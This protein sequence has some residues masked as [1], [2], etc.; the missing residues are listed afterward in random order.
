VNAALDEICRLARAELAGL[1]ELAPPLLGVLDVVGSTAGDRGPGV[2]ADPAFALE[3]LEAA[4]PEGRRLSPA[5]VGRVLD[6]LRGRAGIRE[7]TAHRLSVAEAARD[8]EEEGFALHAARTRDLYRTWVRRLV[9][10]HGEV[11]VAA[12]T[13]VDLAKLVALHTR[14]AQTSPRHRHGL[15]AEE[16]AI[17]AFR[18][19]WAFL[20]QTGAAPRNVAMSLRKPLRPD[21]LRR[22]VRPDEA[23]LL[24][25][26]ARMGSDPLLGETALCLVERLG[27]RPVELGRLRLC[28]VDFAHDELCV[29]GKGDRPRR[30]PVPP[31][32]AALLG[33]YVEDRRP[34]GVPAAV[35]AASPRPLLRRRP[36][37][38]RPEGLGVMAN[39]V[40]DG[41]DR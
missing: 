4:R 36:D 11:E 23:A 6:H 39:Q 18:H 16:A 24:R 37:V 7:V 19:F 28:D 13:A 3:V 26:L 9:L 14:G 2:L 20:V 21:P 33:C 31:G 17:S 15:A 34:E 30:L 8:W 32:L 10:A 40:V 5:V 35:W 29:V 22:P 25:Q 41:L 1:G 12:L 38:C 27:I